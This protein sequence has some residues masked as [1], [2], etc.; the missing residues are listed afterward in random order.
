VVTG[1]N[2]FFRSAGSAVGVAVFG[3]VVNATLGGS[4]IENGRVA[5]A[6]LTTAVHHVFLGTLVLA[7]VMLAAVLLMPRDRGADRTAEQATT[8]VSTG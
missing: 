1:T 4:D 7:V 6:A 8:E 5:P 2:M 3:A